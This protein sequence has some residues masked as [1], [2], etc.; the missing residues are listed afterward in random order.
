MDDENFYGNNK[1]STSKEADESSDSDGS[2]DSSGAEKCPICLLA[3]EKQEIGKPAKCDHVFCFPCILEWSKVMRTCPIDRIEFQDI[4]VY[5]NLEC[6]ELLRTV[7][8]TERV[9]FNEFIVIEDEVTTCEICESS[10]NEDTML[11][12]DG[13]DK[14][15]IMFS[16][17]VSQF[18]E[19]FF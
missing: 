18:H 15:S 1:P 13:C 6:D 4:R 7:A 14:G 16:S 10:A 17:R 12:C 5:D 19:K 9:A 2:A 3:F 11:L 8:V